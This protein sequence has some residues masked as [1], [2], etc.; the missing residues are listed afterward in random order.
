MQ[1]N[2]SKTIKSL[3]S[4]NRVQ[5]TPLISPS[6]ACIKKQLLYGRSES[7]EAATAVIFDAEFINGS[8][9]TTSEEEEEPPWDTKQ[10][11]MRR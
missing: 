2:K 11:Q 7:D 3:S 6:E 9:S 1:N 4:L 10:I 8:R 5:E